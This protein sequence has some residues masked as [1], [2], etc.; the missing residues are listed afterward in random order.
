MIQVNISGIGNSVLNHTPVDFDTARI[1]HDNLPEK[2]KSYTFDASIG[3][4]G[5]AY[6]LDIPNQRKEFY[7]RNSHG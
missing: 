7:D 2:G 1:R 4:D 5:A 3:L 6:D